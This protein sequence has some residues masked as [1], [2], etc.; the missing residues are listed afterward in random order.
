[1]AI[2]V[3]DPNTTANKWD[4]NAGNATGTY[5]AGV[6][7]PKTSQS[8]AAIAAAPRWQAAV[9][10]PDALARFTGHLQKSGDAAWSAGALGKGKDRYAP[11]IHAAKTKYMNNVT[12]YLQAIAGVSLP[13]KG[14]RGSSANYARVQAVGDA[15]HQLK[16][17]RA[18]Q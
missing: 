6:Q 16:L 15:L 5:V 12:P 1:M 18:G 10:S 7:N 3:K 9:A 2:K 17:S 11:G 4:G 13:D 8:A 14:L